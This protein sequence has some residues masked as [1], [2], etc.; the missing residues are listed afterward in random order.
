MGSTKYHYQLKSLFLLISLFILLPTQLLFSQIFTQVTTGDIVQNNGNSGG[1]SWGDYNNDGHIDLF[2]TNYQKNNFLYQNNGDGTFLMINHLIVTNDNG[3]SVSASWGDYDNDGDPDL[4]VSNMNQENFL[5]QNTGD[6]AFIKITSGAIAT[7]ME[8]SYACSWVDYDLDGFLDM[9]V[10]NYG[11]NNSLYHNNGDGTFSKITEGS[12]VNDGGNS[13]GCAWSDYDNDGDPD[14]FVCNANQNNF[15][16]ENNGDGSFTRITDGLLVNDSGDSYSCSWADYNNDGFVDLFVANNREANPLYRNN[17]NGTFTRI[18][19]GPF[20]RDTGNSYSSSWSDYD[21]DG[22][23]DLIV[24]NWNQVNFFYLNNGDETFTKNTNERLADYGD[25]HFSC[26]SGDYNNDGAIDVIFAVKYG[27]NNKLFLNNGNTNNWL[28]LKL[29]GN[30]S[31]TTA[32]GAKIKIQTTV[33]NVSAWQQREISGQTGFASQNSLN[34]A[35]GLGEAT[36][37]DSIIIQWP[38]GIEQVIADI[39]PNQILSL[40][41]PMIYISIPNLNVHTGEFVTI[42][43]NIQFPQYSSFHSAEFTVAGYTDYL[44]FNSVIV[45]SSLSGD[46]GWMFEAN[47]YNDSIVVWFA[48]AN[49]IRGDGVLCWLN[50]FVPEQDSTIIP[51]DFQ[52]VMFDIDNIPVTA[53]SGSVNLLTKYFGDV[54]LN[55]KIQAYD[56]SL[57]LQYLVGNIDL[58]DEQRANANVSLDSS[59]SALDATLI[60]QYGVGLIDTLPYTGNQQDLFAT[61][62]VQMQNTDVESGDQI[63]IPIHIIKAD[64]ILSFEAVIS[65]DPAHLTYNKVNWSSISKN[66]LIDIK[67]N[68]GEIVIAG[69]GT[70]PQQV[71]KGLFA[72]LQ[73]TI[74]ENFD[75]PQTLVTIE[76]LRWNEGKFKKNIASTVLSNASGIQANLSGMP[77]EFSLEQ[78]YPNPFNPSTTIHYSIKERSPVQLTIFNQMGNTI[79]QL[80]NTTQSAGRYSVTWDG[81]NE[82]REPVASGV[83]IYVLKTGINSV[84]SQKMLLI[85]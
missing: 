26:A 23:L 38:S 84:L 48:G 64:N 83:Y 43:V 18:F 3:K 72:A 65:F 39:E 33:N 59:I 74:N 77:Q 22:N 21:N 28:Q 56:A 66:F 36:M 46:Y 85:K 80:V 75:V 13:R 12:I 8:N 78:N 42:P 9:F 32:I 16:Y 79:Q 19:T 34:A 2:I 53:Q 1:S 37:V 55:R 17:G 47:E 68:E 57:I 5:Y 54:D 11:Q 69:A 6:G 45:D 30:T 67:H 62:D 71:E 10:S 60:L 81:T 70:K 49:A 7:D 25:N 15:L 82:I 24:A 4:Y 29:A 73:F 35:F 52:S 76:K 41:E 27:H 58:N 44:Q 61:G 31:N 50:F 40:N 14:L 63:D 20:S 51:L